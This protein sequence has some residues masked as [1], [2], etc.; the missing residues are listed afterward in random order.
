MGHLSFLL[1]IAKTLIESV[2]SL[3]TPCDETLLQVV[4][5]VSLDEDIVA[6]ELL[7]SLF[8]DV[9]CTLDIDIENANF[10]LLND[11]SHG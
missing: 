4:N 9:N 2:L 11:L 5:G 3:R 10:A 1:C 6:L 8:R 7:S